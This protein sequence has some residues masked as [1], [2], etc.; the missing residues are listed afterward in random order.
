MQVDDQHYCSIRERL[1]QL[2]VSSAS[3]REQLQM[4][5]KLFDNCR[6]MMSGYWFCRFLYASVIQTTCIL[7]HV[8]YTVYIKL[9]IDLKL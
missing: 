1:A 4:F 6:K 5:G 8:V 3:V 7:V 2:E 9:F